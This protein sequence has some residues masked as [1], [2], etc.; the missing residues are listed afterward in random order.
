MA[1]FSGSLVA[2]VTPFRNG[3]LDE[4]ALRQLTHWHIEQGTNGLVPVGTTGESPSL[5]SFEHKRIIE[6][7]VAEAS[8]RVP[9]V[10]GAG[11]NNPIEAIEYSLHAE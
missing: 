2:M 4:E 7:V 10:A 6:I 11:S 5:S 1:L 9:V 8:G 3:K